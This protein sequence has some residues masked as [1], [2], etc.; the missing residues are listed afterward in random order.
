M[1]FGRLNGLVLSLNFQNYRATPLHQLLLRL[2]VGHRELWKGKQTKV[3]LLT[4]PCRRDQV[5]GPPSAIKITP[6]DRNAVIVSWL[7]P[8]SFGQ[9]SSNNRIFGYIVY[10][11]FKPPTSNSL[12]SEEITLNASSFGS[13]TI[14]ARVEGL[15]QG[16]YYQFSVSAVNHQ[17]CGQ[18]LTKLHFG[19][20]HR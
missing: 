6:S 15:K 10:K 11:T 18:K 4:R 7:P 12:K 9:T 1:L 16:I 13:G 17:V 14:Y 20:C 5:S 8:V 2:V 3:V 19:S